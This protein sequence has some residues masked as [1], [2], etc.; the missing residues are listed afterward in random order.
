MY[1]YAELNDD[2][3]CIAIHV[4]PAVVS[5]PK[6]IR[7]PSDNPYLIGQYWNAELSEFQVVYYYACLNDK[8]LVEETVSFIGAPQETTDRFREITYQQYLTVKGLWWNG[9]EYV[10]PPIHIKA[11][12][13]TDEINYKDED[14]WLTTVLEEM[15]LD[16]TNN[17]T[18]IEA[19]DTGIREMGRGI[20]TQFGTVDSA[21]QA[22]G[23]S[24]ERMRDTIGALADKDVLLD[25]RVGDLET[26]LA[27]AKASIEV[28]SSDNGVLNQRIDN[29]VV[30]IERNNVQIQLAKDRMDGIASVVE[31][32]V[33]D[34]TFEI[35]KA[36]TV[37][38]FT[39][40]EDAVNDLDGRVNSLDEGLNALKSRVSETESSLANVED[41]IGDLE[42]EVAGVISKANTN[43]SSI[44]SLG[45]RATNVENRVTAVERRA[46]ALESS[47][48]TNKANI[49]TVTSKANTNATNISSLTTKVNTNTTSINTLKTDMKNYLPL[50]GG[51]MNGD[52]NVKGVLR[53]EGSQ[54]FYYN[55]DAKTM[56]I[57][58]NNAT[59]VN[60]GGA[61][62]GGVSYFNSA[63]L[64]P[65]SV[66]PRNSDSL[67][68]N[69]TYRWKGIY[70]QTAVNVSSDERL[71]ENVKKMDGDNL[72]DFVNALNVVSYQY[73]GD[74]MGVERIGLIAQ[75][76]IKADPSLAR[77]F[78]SCDGDGYYSLRPADLVFPLIAAVQKLQREVDKLKGE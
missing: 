26:D 69:A 43:A 58:T 10:E 66:V 77:Y 56:N 71:K 51:A 75:E 4:F 48:E 46:T 76:V 18:R 9:T 6:Y 25:T 12:A 50:T 8:G 53:M 13:S 28:L 5:D 70:S 30:A 21:L 11:V 74:D 42:S 33:S 31:S 7:V 59:V 47:V 22:V 34:E 61:H 55:V 45:T 36:E 1:Y 60:F 44:S 54:A 14:V 67:L 24:I 49:T 62:S 27:S 64:R 37:E 52:L 23:E 39:A 17:R 15:Q 68:G 2:N 3:I 41:E 78:V 32:K 65:Y 16:T 29:N 72:A 19:L 57:G 40:A 35:F 73:I 38:N 63:L 20:R